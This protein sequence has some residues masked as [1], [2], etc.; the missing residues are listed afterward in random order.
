[1]LQCVG[2]RLPFLRAPPL[3]YRG[4]HLVISSVG[5]VVVPKERVAL[6]ACIANVFIAPRLA[7]SG[8]SVPTCSELGRLAWTDEIKRGYLMKSETEHSMLPL[9]VTSSSDGTMRNSAPQFQQSTGATRTA[10]LTPPIAP[11]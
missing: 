3:E 8:L 9:S 1:M 11:R 10:M 5:L 6:E 4:N 7:G 2:H